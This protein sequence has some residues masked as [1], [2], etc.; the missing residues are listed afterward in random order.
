MNEVNR[1][2]PSM[3]VGHMIK[4]K[5]GLWNRSQDFDRVTAERDAALGLS[6]ENILMEVGP[7]LGW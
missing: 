6:V 1:Y 5:D 2:T 7:G 3:R 4:D